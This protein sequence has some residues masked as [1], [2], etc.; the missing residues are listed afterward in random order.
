[1]ATT[2]ASA[3]PEIN[4]AR[5]PARRRAARRR[6]ADDPR[7]RPRVRARAAAAGRGRVVRGGRRCRRASSRKRARRARPARACTCEGY[8]CAGS[9]AVAY[10]LA[11]LELE[12]GD[13]GLRSLVSVQGSLVD[14]RDL[15][16]RLGGAEAGVAPA[17]GR[18]RGDRL[19]RAD[20]ARRGLRPRLDAH[21][22]PPRRRRLDPVRH[23]DVDHE[24]L[25]RRRRRGLGA[26]RRPASAAS[27]SRRGRPGSPRRTSTRSSRCA[28]RSPPS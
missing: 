6:G 27:S 25:G 2:T 20:R 26:H 18:G 10:G 24:R 4:A 7:H 1:M 8:G 17:D 3:P 28:P 16:L 11:C 12:A 22:R 5:L 15:A 14:V 19:L 21:P 13:A 9:S 23:E